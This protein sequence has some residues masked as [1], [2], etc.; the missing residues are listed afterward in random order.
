MSIRWASEVNAICG[1][2]FAS[3]AIRSC[4][5]D[6]LVEFRSIRRV[7]Q[8]RFHDPTPRFPPL[9]PG[10]TRSPVSSV[11]SRRYDFLSPLPPRFVA[12]A[13]RYLGCTRSVRSGADECAA[14]AWSWS[15][16]SS[17]RDVPR[18]RQDLPSSWGTPLVRL[19]MFHTDAGRTASTRPL[20]C[21]G[22]ALGHRTAKAPAKGLS[23]L[24][25]MAFGLAVYASQCKLPCPTQDWL[26]AAGQALPD[27]PST[28][29]VPLK[30]FRSA[31][32][33][34]SSL[35]KFSWRNRWDR[36]AQ[37]REPDCIRWGG[38]TRARAEV[39]L[40]AA[41]RTL[42]HH[43]R[44]GSRAGQLMNLSRWGCRSS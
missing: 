8:G 34:S 28:R 20:R 17:N 33:I 10:G 43:A 13:W 29:K 31:S 3:A 7:S 37:P 41:K 14:Q 21:R 18:K 42:S 23:T 44:Y 30:G 36:S 27:G 6:T 25:S 22:M 26:P 35:P 16:G 12:F 11:L 39:G 5:V 4:F 2:C 15:P 19:R 32:Y 24:N 1:D 40:V 9:A 38:P